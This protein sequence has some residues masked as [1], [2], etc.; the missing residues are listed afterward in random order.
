MRCFRT[1][2]AAALCA[3]I[4]GFALDALAQKGPPDDPARHAEER[5]FGGPPP[6]HRA[7]G[8]GSTCKTSGS[9]CTLE[10]N[11]SVGA[12]CSCTGKNGKKTDGKVVP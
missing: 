11:E 4:A 8:K 5:P 9:T 2:I 1:I 6:K 3:G 10:K 7:F 12:K